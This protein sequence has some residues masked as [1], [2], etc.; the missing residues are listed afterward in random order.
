MEATA[1]SKAL[2]SIIGRGCTL[3]SIGRVEIYGV[4]GMEQDKYL[5]DS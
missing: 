1:P 2:C 5:K 3:Y 4:P